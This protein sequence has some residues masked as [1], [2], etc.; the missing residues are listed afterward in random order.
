MSFLKLFLRV[1]YYQQKRVKC[2]YTFLLGQEWK[3]FEQGYLAAT[4]KNDNHDLAV[5][6]QKKKSDDFN[7]ENDI[8]SDKNMEVRPN[9]NPIK[10]L[11][12]TSL[13]NR[14]GAPLQR[15][16]TLKAKVC[17]KKLKRICNILISCWRLRKYSLDSN[18]GM[19]LEANSIR[20]LIV[21]ISPQRVMILVS[22]SATK[23]QVTLIQFLM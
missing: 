20:Y 11:N 18:H 21:K 12:S 13:F 15:N 19:R 3:D 8:F 10:L 23:Q 16:Q 6:A 22:L 7:E 17:Q 4:L 2:I 1:N 5:A 9:K 14:N